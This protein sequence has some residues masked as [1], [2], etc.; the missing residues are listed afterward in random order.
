MHGVNWHRVVWIAVVF[1]IVYTAGW[2]LAWR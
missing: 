1:Y 2:G